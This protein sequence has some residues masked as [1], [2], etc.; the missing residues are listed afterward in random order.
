MIGEVH[1][2]NNEAVIL[3]AFLKPTSK[4]LTAK[5]MAVLCCLV[6]CDDLFLC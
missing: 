3:Y 5:F 6:L 4:L 2:E 1:G